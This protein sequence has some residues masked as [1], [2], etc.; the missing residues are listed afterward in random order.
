MAENKNP[1]KDEIKLLKPKTDIVFQSLFNASH[2]E[3]TKAFA[4]ALLGEQIDKITINEE[5]TLLREKINDKL[6]VLDLE[7]DVNNNKKVDVEIQLVD[8][9]NFVE[10]LLFYFSKLYQAQIK[11]GSN[12]LDAKKVVLI[13]IIDYPFELT[14]EVVEMETIWKLLEKGHLNLELTDYLE[15]RIL[16]LE[17]VRKAYSDNK[18]DEKAQWLLFLDDPNSQEVKEIMEKNYKIK[19]ATFIVREMSEDEQMQRIADL[20]EKA[21]MDEK[22]IYAAGIEQGKLEQ[23]ENIVK[24]LYKMKKTIMEIS[25]IVD[26]TED[27]IKKILNIK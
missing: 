8:K 23:Q 14:K 3:T 1:T 22:A 6:G 17:K 4:Q 12:Y 16:E 7:L 27:E 19:D 2:K 24:K 11:K 9:K 18:D 20:R 25:Q 26:M 10:R 15:I 5:K 13:A 21:I